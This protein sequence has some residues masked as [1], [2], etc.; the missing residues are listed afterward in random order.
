MNKDLPNPEYDYSYIFPYS[1]PQRWHFEE[2][3]N[4]PTCDTCHNKCITI[5]ARVFYKKE[6][7]NY[8]SKTCWDKLK[9]LK[10]G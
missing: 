2:K 6:I 4:P 7:E 5:F 1:P 10:N 3:K 9:G 8:C